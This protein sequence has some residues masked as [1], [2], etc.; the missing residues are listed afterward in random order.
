MQEKNAE[1]AGRSS[2]IVRA[3]RRVP[4]VVC[5]QLPLPR[6]LPSHHERGA[7]RKD[8]RCSSFPSPF[9]ISTKNAHCYL[10]PE[11]CW[12][13]SCRMYGARLQS[14]ET[15]R[16]GISRS[17]RSTEHRNPQHTLDPVSADKQYGSGLCCWTFCNAWWLL[18]LETSRSG[19]NSNGTLFTSAAVKNKAV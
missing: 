9:L 15:K 16:Q 1:V 6:F 17:P 2:C 8:E 14:G 19:G 7:L 3:G 18:L 10:C 13:R 4:A 11:C 5:R 12:Q